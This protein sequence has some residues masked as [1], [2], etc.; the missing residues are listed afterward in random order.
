L[1]WTCVGCRENEE[2]GGGLRRLPKKN[3]TTSTFFG[4]GTKKGAVVEG[5]SGRLFED[6]ENLIQ[7]KN[8]VPAT[9]ERQETLNNKD[10]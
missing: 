9:R 6:G 7:K 1:G 3:S 2:L 10:R 8:N 5:G 4:S